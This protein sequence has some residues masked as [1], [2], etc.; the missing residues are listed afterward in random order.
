MTYEE[1]VSKYIDEGFTEEEAI[2]KAK[3]DLEEQE[4]L[5]WLR[6]QEHTNRR[7]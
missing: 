2:Q 7:P 5:D 6:Y 4:Q 1:L 3:Q